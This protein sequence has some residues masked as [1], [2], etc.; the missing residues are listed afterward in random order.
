M[1]VFISLIKILS[2]R[3]PKPV[4][5]SHLCHPI[6]MPL[7]TCIYDVYLKKKK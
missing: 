1:H 3:T 5:W 2:L 7:P 4:T 6:I